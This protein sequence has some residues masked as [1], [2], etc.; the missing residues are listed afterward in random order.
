[1]ALIVGS[2]V[3]LVRF[4]WKT[5]LA[6]NASL[7][8]GI[9]GV[10]ASLGT[11]LAPNAVL[12]FL[13]VLSFYD[14]VAVY[15]TGHMVRMFRELSA[16]GVVFAFMLTPLRWRAMSAPAIHDDGARRPMFLGTGDVA[17]PV[18]LSASALRVGPVPAVLSLTGAAIGFAAMYLLF[19]AQPKRSPMPALPPI[20][21][22]SILGYL[23]SV[24]ILRL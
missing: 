19:L 23:A 6:M 5:P 14:I 13:T 3:V 21:L 9:A 2:A 18:M 15:R 4:V 24:L 16:R 7:A 22:G 10:S 8:V 12:V 20:A 1:L 11:E 17:L